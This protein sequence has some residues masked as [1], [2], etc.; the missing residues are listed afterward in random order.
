MRPFFITRARLFSRSAL[1]TVSCRRHR[2]SVPLSSRYQG[3]GRPPSSRSDLT[4]C[5]SV[6]VDKLRGRR[7]LSVAEGGCPASLGV[8]DLGGCVEG[9]RGSTTATGGPQEI[10]PNPVDRGEQD[11][12]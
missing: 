10:S 7:A 1:S 3:T 4:L 5:L 9:K 2:G 11:H 12:A 6:A 8:G